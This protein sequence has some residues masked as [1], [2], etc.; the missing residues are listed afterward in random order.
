MEADLQAAEARVEA[1]E[2]RYRRARRA[3]ERELA[4]EAAPAA[5]GPHE[6]TPAPEDVPELEADKEPTHLAS[7]TAKNTGARPEKEVSRD[8]WLAA[9]AAESRVKNRATKARERLRRS[10]RDRKF[11]WAEP[12]A[13]AAPESPVKAEAPAP[14]EPKAPAARAPAADT[15]AV[16]EGAQGLVE[17]L[18]SIKERP[19]PAE[20]HTALIRVV[21]G[22]RDSY[23]TF[24]P[25]DVVNDLKERGVLE[26]ALADEFLALLKEAPAAKP[27]EVPAEGWAAGAQKASGIERLDDKPFKEEELGYLK[28]VEEKALMAAEAELEAAEA[29]LGKLVSE[30]ETRFGDLGDED[31]AAP[32]RQVSG[33]V[34]VDEDEADRLEAHYDPDGHRESRGSKNTSAL[35]SKVVSRDRWEK[36][37]SKEGRE[38]EHEAKARDARR[39]EARDMKQGA[40]DVA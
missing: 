34:R 40:A 6:T 7:H 26:S 12:G 30:A 8:K 24:E 18:K 19:S 22:G 27:A 38:R 9:R 16:K 36:A 2:G 20:K 21:T 37:H 25:A 33:E 14:E 15:P 39:S 31:G 11:Q 23:Y 29:Q 13:E 28:C 35:P 4:D 10:A 17:R 1:A 5:Q 32:Q 3:I